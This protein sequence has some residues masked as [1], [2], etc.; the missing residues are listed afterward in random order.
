MAY[1]LS[2]LML[3]REDLLF[4]FS[5]VFMIFLGLG[6]SFILRFGLLCLVEFICDFDL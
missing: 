2:S 1:G 5:L 6:L 3:N 4:S